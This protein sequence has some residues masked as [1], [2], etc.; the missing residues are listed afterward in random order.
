GE[1]KFKY[2][3]Q[4]G[5]I[6]K[7]GSIKFGIKFGELCFNFNNGC[8]PLNLRKIPTI[9]KAFGLGSFTGT[10]KYPKWQFRVNDKK[11]STLFGSLTEQELGI[12]L[13]EN[14]SCLVETTFQVN[15]NSNNLGVIEQEGVWD[16]GTNKK[17]KETKIR[18]FL[19]KVV[20]PKIK[21]YVSKV[22]LKYDSTI[23][24]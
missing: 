13:L 14:T 7:E 12:M 15:V 16:D 21:D 24:S 22:V 19:K 17:V 11:R 2:R 9:E 23:N 4:L 8:M 6:E 1:E 3:E 10:D 5:L 18:A 20:E